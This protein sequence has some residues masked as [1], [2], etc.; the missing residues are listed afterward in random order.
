M[1]FDKFRS[2]FDCYTTD[3][4]VL[5]NQ[6]K[7]SSSQVS[8]SINEQEEALQQL[9]QKGKIHSQKFQP[10][11]RGELGAQSR[12]FQEDFKSDLTSIMCTTS[13]SLKVTTTFKT[14]S[15]IVS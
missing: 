10:P 11:A 1:S 13:T 14:Y 12:L 4:Q 2:T 15:D 7:Q 3:M 5:N 9:V 8:S 6:V